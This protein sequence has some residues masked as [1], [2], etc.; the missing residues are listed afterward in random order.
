[1]DN[2]LHKTANV[3]VALS[4]VKWAQLGRRLVQARVSSENTTA[5]TLSTDNC[6]VLVLCS[7]LVQCARRDRTD[8]YRV[9]WS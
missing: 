1:M 5:L 2:V 4:K 7:R 6:I 8:T 3:T 9:P